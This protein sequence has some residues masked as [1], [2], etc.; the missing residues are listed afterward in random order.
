[1]FFQFA[2]LESDYQELQSRYLALRQRQE[3]Q[4][5][6]LEF[7]AE[8]N[9]VAVEEL[10]EAL[11][12]LRRRKEEEEASS[13]PS[14]LEDPNKIIN[15]NSTAATPST[16][17]GAAAAE[18]TRVRSELSELQVQY[19]ESSAELD[20]TRS[21]LKVQADISAE[22]GRESEALKERIAQVKQ[23]FSSQAQEYKRLLDLRAARIQ[24]L[25]AQVRDSAYGNLQRAAARADREDD[26]RGSG[27]GG[28]AFFGSS[29]G[30]T[31]VHTSSGQSLFE[32]HV[33]RARYA[34]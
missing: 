17:S 7:F 27:S 4:K 10:E 26:S 13:M 18:L 12:Q 31:S 28:G 23:E 32:I 11:M 9:A 14:F 8:E 29:G 30:A 24:K 21:L 6:K 15:K 33:Q 2:K 19:V 5:E 20:K 16:P 34:F 22:R 1:M 25:E 3:V